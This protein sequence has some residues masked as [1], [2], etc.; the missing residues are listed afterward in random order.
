MWAGRRVRL[1]GMTLTIATVNVNGIR[2]AV[3]QR[4][5]DNP[6]MLPWLEQ[7]PADVVLMQE[8]RADE[9]QTQA[10]LAPALEAGWQLVQAPA[11]AKGRA[12]VGILSRLPLKDVQ[13]GFSMPVAFPLTEAG[14]ETSATSASLSAASFSFPSAAAQAAAEFDDSGRYIEA[15]VEAPGG[16]VRVASLYLT[17]GSVDTD[18]QD[19]KYRFQDAFG[20]YLDEYAAAVRSG[21]A[22][23]LVVGGDWNICHRRA[24]LKNWKTNRNKAGFLPDERAFLDSVVGTFPDEATQIGDE[25]DA[26]RHGNP[27]GNVGD[28][29]GAV[30]YRPTEMAKRRLQR[31]AP[32]DPQWFDIVR[33]LNPDVEGPYSWWTY[34]GQAFD[35]DAGW[36][37]DLQV[38]TA[39]LLERA[40]RANNAWV[41]RAPAYNQRWSD[42]SPVV[43]EYADPR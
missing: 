40:Q 33:R 15:T 2:A 4:N 41:D 10:A 43:V 20:V 35:T 31:G 29:F 6:G 39:G 9:K 27:A 32:T 22:P 7:T 21:T 1:V 25:L 24:D 18:K 28:F 13:V 14:T 17:S 23:E 11:A 30:D 42:H 3:K 37:I 34:R 36:R 8:V 12:G 26:G 19:E 38:A 5:E 16:E